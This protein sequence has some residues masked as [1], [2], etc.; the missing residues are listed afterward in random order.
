MGG[1]SV[2]IPLN[3]ALEG[4]ESVRIPVN[5]AMCGYLKQCFPR[6]LAR[7]RVLF[8]FGCRLRC[9]CPSPVVFS[10]A[11][12]FTYGAVFN[13]FACGHRVRV[14]LPTLL[15]LQRGATKSRCTCGA[16]RRVS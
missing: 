4:R 3:I 16:T 7:G 1:Q 6:T 13:V 10:P 15:A 12:L 14:R 11:S 8:S 9:A 5:K 2:R